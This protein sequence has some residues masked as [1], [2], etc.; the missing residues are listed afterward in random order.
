MESRSSNDIFG[1]ICCIYFHLTII[2]NVEGLYHAVKVNYILLS[3]DLY[4]NFQTSRPTTTLQMFSAGSEPV[5]K[6]VLKK[7]RNPKWKFIR[8]RNLTERFSFPH[9]APLHLV[10]C[11]SIITC[12]SFAWFPVISLRLQILLIA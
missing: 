11:L 12:F 5:F 4:F 6:R 10:S 1:R 2:A 9:S 3:K 8:S 7:K